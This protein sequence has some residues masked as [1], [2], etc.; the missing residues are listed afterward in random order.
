MA[1]GRSAGLS[2]L[3]NN[4]RR[5][6]QRHQ[7]RIWG[8]GEPGRG[9]TFRFAVRLARGACVNPGRILLAEDNANDIELTLA[10]LREHDL[11]D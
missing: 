11:A 2:A 3:I 7:A 4:A 6:A 8:E 9:A 5:V 1:P 10:A